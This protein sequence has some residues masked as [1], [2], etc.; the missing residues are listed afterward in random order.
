MGFFKYNLLNK[1]SNVAENNLLRVT[2]SRN[3]V[4]IQVEKPT[5]IAIYT[6]T[7]QLLYKQMINDAVFIRLDKGGYILN[8]YSE[9]GMKNKKIIIH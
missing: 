3:T 6:L 1:V 5:D 7:G 4:H 2:I 8:A 9:A